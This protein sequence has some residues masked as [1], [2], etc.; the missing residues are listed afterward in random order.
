[1]SWD[2]GA[3]TPHFPPENILYQFPIRFYLTQHDG[4]IQALCFLSW[5]NLSLLFNLNHVD[6]HDKL[7]ILNMIEYDYGYVLMESCYYHY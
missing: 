4:G 1:M 6:V 7:M 2:D 5:C 3:F